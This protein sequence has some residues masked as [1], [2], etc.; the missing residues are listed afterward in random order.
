MSE[1]GS[2]PAYKC[3]GAENIGIDFNREEGF[4]TAYECRT[5]LY[6]G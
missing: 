4:N 6:V 1:C 2:T 3:N 5:V